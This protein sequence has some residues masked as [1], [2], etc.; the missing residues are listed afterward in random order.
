MPKLQQITETNLQYLALQEAGGADV[1]TMA[2]S[3]GLSEYLVKKITQEDHLEGRNKALYEK[4]QARARIQVH[5]GQIRHTVT[6]LGQHSYDDVEAL[7]YALGY[8]Q[9]AIAVPGVPPPWTASG[10]LFGYSDSA[11]SMVIFN[12][13]T[14]QAMLFESP[15]ETSDLEGFVFLTALSDPFGVIVATVGD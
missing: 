14:G 13:T 9:S 15:L 2:L 1:K 8:G 10:A 7:E 3:T 6:E 11:N 4:H 12:P 5:A